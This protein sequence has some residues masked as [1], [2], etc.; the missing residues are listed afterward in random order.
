MV[1]NAKRLVA[2]GLIL[3]GLVGIFM[4][5]H[6]MGEISEAKGTINFVTKPFQNDPAGGML[7]RGLMSRASQ[8]D[9]QVQMML[10][11]GILC[12]VAGVVVLYYAC[13]K[14]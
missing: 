8:Y 13:R 11:G 2:V 4:A 6:Y 10:Y 3:L 12:V 7:K 1:W 9:Q 14:K 5:R